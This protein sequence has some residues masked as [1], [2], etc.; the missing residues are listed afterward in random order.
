MTQPTDRD[1]RLL[2]CLYRLADAVNDALISHRDGTLTVDGALEHISW[3]FSRYQDAVRADASAAAA[4]AE[5]PDELAEHRVV[6]RLDGGDYELSC[7]GCSLRG[8]APTLRAA[9]KTKAEHEEAHR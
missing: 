2:P 3:A 6:I 1:L 5:V 8:L 9:V 7:T 4:A